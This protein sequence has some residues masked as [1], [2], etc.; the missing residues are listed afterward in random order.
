MGAYVQKKFG[1]F[2]IL[3][4]KNLV[5]SSPQIS[6]PSHDIPPETESL[7]NIV[8]YELYN[9]T[10][11]FDKDIYNYIFLENDFD[12]WLENFTEY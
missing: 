1:F 2:F 11:S 3:S 12:T 7:S 10:S 8:I 4:K 6:I 9:T 5:V